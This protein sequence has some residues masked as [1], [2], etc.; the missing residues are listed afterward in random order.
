M[1]DSISSLIGSGRFAGAVHDAWSLRGTFL[2]SARPAFRRSAIEARSSLG[3]RMIPPP[4]PD[5][6]RSGFA[7]LNVLDVAGG[8]VRLARCT[9]AACEKLFGARGYLAGVPCADQARDQLAVRSD[10]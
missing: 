4:L 6:I 8:L 1:S 9:L 3:T 2:R 10:E 5:L 7:E